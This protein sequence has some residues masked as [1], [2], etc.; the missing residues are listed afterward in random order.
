VRTP[1]GAQP[2]RKPTNLSGPAA[3][4][5]VALRR[6]RPVTVVMLG[7]F[8]DRFIADISSRWPRTWPC[9][10]TGLPQHTEKLVWAADS[11]AAGKL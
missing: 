9:C 2:P 1:R 6:F 11:V 8:A 7:R 4:T 5:D 10:N 3:R